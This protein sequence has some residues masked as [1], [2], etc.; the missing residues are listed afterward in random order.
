M[1][2]RFG[3]AAPALYDAQHEQANERPGARGNTEPSCRPQ[4]GVLEQAADDAEPGQHHSGT[5]A[6]AAQEKEGAHHNIHCCTSSGS[7]SIPS[8]SG[9]FTMHE[10]RSSPM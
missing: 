2:Q 1:L 7:G 6:D 4:I 10:R 8:T 3:I 9:S 5:P